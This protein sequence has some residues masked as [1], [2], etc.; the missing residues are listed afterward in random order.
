MEDYRNICFYPDF[1][2]FWNWLLSLITAKKFFLSRDGVQHV[3]TDP[4]FKPTNSAGY[5]KKR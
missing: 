5:G 2:P 4:S 3:K 1:N